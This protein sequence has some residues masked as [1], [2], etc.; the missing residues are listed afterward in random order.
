[1]TR[2]E[3]TSPDGSRRWCS[4]ELL[5]VEKRLE[6]TYRR[7]RKPPHDGLED[8]NDAFTERK[9][10]LAPKPSGIWW[11]PGPS[12]RWRLYRHYNS[13]S[14]V[15]ELLGQV[16]WYKGGLAGYYVSETPIRVIHR[17]TLASCVRALI[18]AV[19]D[20]V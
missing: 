9:R 6:K 2:H 20:A 17:G 7:L 4:E 14:V 10:L 19:R 8:V 1:M 11:R 5:D 15:M 13:C 12:R 3:F 16:W 18:D